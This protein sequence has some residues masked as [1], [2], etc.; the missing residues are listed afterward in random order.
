MP[1][2]SGRHVIEAD[3]NI[4]KG[5]VTRQIAID[6]MNVPIDR[7]N[8]FLVYRGAPCS[9]GQ[10]FVACSFF[11]ILPGSCHDVWFVVVL[12]VKWRTRRLHRFMSLFIVPSIWLVADGNSAA[13]TCCY[14]STDGT[15][16]PAG[17]GGTPPFIFLHTN[18]G[19]HYI[20]LLKR[21]NLL[22]LCIVSKLFRHVF[23]KL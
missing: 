13:T 8:S 7:M 20:L 15:A 21:S 3:R 5:P 18:E 10:T 12:V 9:V 23:C 2:P 16:W 14:R 17:G 22:R 19:C 6:T 1:N 4:D 11:A